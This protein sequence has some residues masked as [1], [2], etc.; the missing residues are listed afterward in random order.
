[1]I[2]T[3][4]NAINQTSG[5][6]YQSEFSTAQPGYM[7]DSEPVKSWLEHCKLGSSFQPDQAHGG[8]RPALSPTAPPAGLV[9]VRPN[10]W[11]PSS[12]LQQAQGD[13]GLA[14][15]IAAQ[16]GNPDNAP[17]DDNSFN[18]SA[19][20]P[21]NA[22]AAQF[23]TKQAQP[24]SP[25]PMHFGNPYAFPEASYEQHKSKKQFASAAIVSTPR[26]NTTSPITAPD[27]Q[28]GFGAAGASQAMFNT[29]S[30]FLPDNQQQ[31]NFST[32]GDDAASA[33][34]FK[35]PVVGVPFVDPSSS[36]I[37]P[38]CVLDNHSLFS[39]NLNSSTEH[40]PKPCNTG[41]YAKSTSPF[42]Q[43]APGLERGSSNALF[44]GIPGS[45]N[46]PLESW[47]AYGNYWGPTTGPLPAGQGVDGLPTTPNKQHRMYSNSASAPYSGNANVSAWG[48]H[49]VK[50]PKHNYSQSS[51]LQPGDGTTANPQAGNQA[52]CS[53]C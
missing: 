16:G 53:A 32:T 4:L 27:A 19:E 14:V 24:D 26:S 6:Q 12:A 15:Q 18:W 46:A 13:F 45:E 31:Y 21:W 44:G 48:G 40:T 43:V 52:I 7:M 37:S 50:Q 33:F 22:A 9:Q 41:W 2:S 25:S 28:G 8:S 35:S 47:P 38:Q 20:S 34:A 17:A 51:K 1:M 42:C 3:S 49:A 30:K 10:V 36:F 23:G 29:A 39:Y 5:A 11:L